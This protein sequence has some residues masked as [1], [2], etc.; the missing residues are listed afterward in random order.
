MQQ[1]REDVAQDLDAETCGAL[2]RALG[3]LDEHERMPIVLHF[4][5]GLT[6]TQVGELVGV[7]QSV[8]AR[9]I[10]S[11]LD[12]LRV[13]LT[14]TGVTAG[15]LVLPQLLQRSDLLLA[16]ESLQKALASTALLKSTI[17]GSLAAHLSCSARQSVRRGML[18]TRL[19]LGAVAAC[20]CAFV[21]LLTLYGRTVPSPEAKAQAPA[22][23]NIPSSHPSDIATQAHVRKTWDFRTGPLDELRL[24]QGEWRWQS[25]ESGP[26][27]MK[28]DSTHDAGFVLPVTLP[29][30]PTRVRITQKIGPKQVS[31]SGCY[32]TD[33]HRVPARTDFGGQATGQTENA[34]NFDFYVLGRFILGIYEGRVVSV[35]EYAREYPEEQLCVTVKNMT[36]LSVEVRTITLEEVPKAL[37]K[38]ENLVLKIA[39]PG[40]RHPEWTIP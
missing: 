37:R 23:P 14:Q 33:S 18:R 22:A 25:S 34:M 32:W 13:R 38:P 1:R 4:M 29:R 15:A 27:G 30:K 8:V 11:G 3:S 31:T 7:T 26:A 5:E 28:I 40:A 35:N 24:F 39:S 21:G 2:A 19:A 10:A 20:T 17:S 12:A 16:S 6:Q 9:R 36:L